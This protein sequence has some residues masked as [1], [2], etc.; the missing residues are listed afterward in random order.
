MDKSRRYT[1]VVLCFW[2]DRS[3]NICVCRRRVLSRV[4]AEFGICLRIPRAGFGC[5][6]AAGG[7]GVRNKEYGGEAE[8]EGDRK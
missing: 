5:R 8:K 4:D 3:I 1:R 7:R 6:Q 2:E